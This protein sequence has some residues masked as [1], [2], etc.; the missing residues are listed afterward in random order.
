[1]KSSWTNSMDVKFPSEC[2]RKRTRELYEKSFDEVRYV[3]EG[4]PDYEHMFTSLVQVNC[5]DDKLAK[6]VGVMSWRDST[7]KTK[8]TASAKEESSED[9]T[10][11]MTL[12]EL[13]QRVVRMMT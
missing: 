1:M 4:R 6:S 12:L 5:W 3:E 2:G 13:F 8:L 11:S 9:E 10:E 7:E